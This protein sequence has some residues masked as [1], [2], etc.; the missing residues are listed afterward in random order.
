MQ[1]YLTA[2][3][4]ALLVACGALSSE[5]IAQ[6][7]IPTAEQNE[8]E[9]RAAYFEKVRTFVPD[10]EE[11]NVNPEFLIWLDKIEPRWGI[12]RQSYLNDSFYN[13][14][15]MKTAFVFKLYKNYI[16]G[17]SWNLLGAN[18]VGDFFYLDMR[19]IATVNGRF[20]KAWL[21]I[22]STGN[23]KAPY[24]QAKQLIYFDCPKGLHSLMQNI[25]YNAEGNIIRSDTYNKF[26]GISP[27]PDT[28]SQTMLKIVCSSKLR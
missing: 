23:P 20:R 18:V 1:G 24:S 2:S 27:V 11:I 26:D 22:D 10:Y 21:K 14:D 9:K 28:P 8:S 13:F 7:Q 19:S 6:D 16:D 5:A 25:S 15:A 12:T 3:A 17:Y 4:I